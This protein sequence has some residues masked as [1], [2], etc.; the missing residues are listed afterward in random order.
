MRLKAYLLDL[1]V[2][3][4][5]RHGLDVTRMMLQ[6][7]PADIKDE[8]S[9]DP[10]GINQQ[11][12]STIGTLQATPIHAFFPRQFRLG[13]LYWQLIVHLNEPQDFFVRHCR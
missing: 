2:P 1:C 13:V 7:S 9:H 11:N 12:P 6:P 8:S 3:N 4:L 5:R 10:K